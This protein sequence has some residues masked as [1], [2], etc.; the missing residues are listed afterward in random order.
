MRDRNRE[1]C[2]RRFSSLDHADFTRPPCRPHPRSLDNESMSKPTLL[3]TTLLTLS[4]CGDNTDIPE[5]P[6][7]NVELPAREPGTLDK[8]VCFPSD[9]RTDLPWHGANRETLTTWMDS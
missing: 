4:A 5:L 7:D 2:R 8:K 3:L 1:R 9:L 6:D